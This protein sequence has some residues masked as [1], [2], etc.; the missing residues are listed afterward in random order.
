MSFLIG[1][2]MG[3]RSKN[4][5]VY[6][7]F[8]VFLSIFLVWYLLSRI[9]TGDLL[10]TFGNLYLPTLFLYIFLSLCGTLARA[11]RYFILISPR[12]MKFSEIVLVTMVRNLFVDLLPARTGSLS[13]IYL[14]NRRFGLPFEIAASSFLMASIFDLIVIFPILFFAIFIIGDNSLP[15]MSPF[16][17]I[18]SFLLFT[19]MILFLSFLSNIIKIFTDL[20]SLFFKK[21]GVEENL[22]LKVLKEKLLLTA[23][24]IE[25]IWARKLFTPLFL[26]S[27]AVRIFK[28]SSLYFLL[29]SVLVHLNYKMV[30]LNFLK[31]FLG[32]LGAEFSA[33][34][35]VHGL[36][37]IGTWESA[38]ALTFKLLGFFDMNV[39][40][41]SGFGVHITAQVFEYSLGILSIIVLYLPYKRSKRVVSF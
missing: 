26:S 29:H 41:I 7:T 19:S 30:D 23:G 32:I 22:R 14:V 2:K 31:V 8:S 10:K 3:V 34:L 11:Y 17:I 12:Q 4:S 33:M 21:L 35:P 9:E 38:W 5:H 16:F 25:N 18:I 28:Y 13:Y 39:A 24:D 20:L 37:G 15:F 27:L 1:V 6:F 36:A 40:I